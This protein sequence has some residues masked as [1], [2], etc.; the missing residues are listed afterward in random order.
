MHFALKN[1]LSNSLLGGLTNLVGRVIVKA[2]GAKVK[3]RKGDK[4]AAA[5]NQEA[6]AAAGADD[7]SGNSASASAGEK[8]PS[9][10]GNSSQRGMA[11]AEVALP[12]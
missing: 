1:V 11:Q 12:R 10:F 4:D 7:A 5:D 2:A 8:L 6:A 3:G 9:L